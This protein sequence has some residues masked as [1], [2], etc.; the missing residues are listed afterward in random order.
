LFV[1]VSVVVESRTVLPRSEY[2]YKATFAQRIILPLMVEAALVVAVILKPFFSLL[3]GHPPTCP[4]FLVVTIEW[5]RMNHNDFAGRSSGGNNHNASSSTSSND[6]LQ[7]LLQQ[8]VYLSQQQ[9]QFR[10]HQ[11]QFLGNNPNRKP[12]H[13]DLFEMASLLL[14]DPSKSNSNNNWSSSRVQGHFSPSLSTNIITPSNSIRGDGTVPM[15]TAPSTHGLPMTHTSC[16]GT[17]DGGLFD[18][19][20]LEQ[21]LGDSKQRQTQPNQSIKKAC[22]VPDNFLFE[23]T[24]DEILKPNP[25]KRSCHDVESILKPTLDGT[26]DNVDFHDGDEPESAWCLI[27]FGDDHDNIIDHDELFLDGGRRIKRSRSFQSEEVFLDDINPNE[28]IG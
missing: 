16:S 24:L 25:R 27:D 20:E 13:D 28:T 8:Q 15:M 9:Q 18:E 7:Q 2:R 23:T 5:D 12:S 21:I 26:L 1:F 14:L 19:E 10:W 17:G 3:V 22:S 4:R 11:Q 6:V